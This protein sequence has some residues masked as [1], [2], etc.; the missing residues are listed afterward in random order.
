MK[1]TLLKYLTLVMVLFVVG[2]KGVKA[3]DYNFSVK[4]Y[5]TDDPENFLTSYNNGTAV[6]I[7]AGGTVNVGEK[8]AVGVYVD[9]KKEASNLFDINL[10]WD[11]N[12]LTPLL[13][14]VT[15]KTFGKIDLRSEY[16]GGIQPDDLE[17]GQY[18]EWEA[19]FKK[20]LK[21]YKND[22]PRI[23]VQL[24][25]KIAYTKFKNSGIL[26]WQF[27][28]VKNDAPANSYFTFSY[29]KVDG[30]DGF[31]RT[32]ADITVTPISF[33]VQNNNVPYSLGDI[34]G[35]GRIDYGDI[36][37]L[38]AYTG[39]LTQLSELEKSAADVN[40]D[41]RVNINDVIKLESIYAEI[42]QNQ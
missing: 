19:S 38:I 21:Y 5:K 42:N 8:I 35:N 11:E 37:L 12:I 4:V 16:E 15:G 7:P 25:D 23:N 33:K 24:Q 10:N 32:E 36:S 34:N 13:S 41:G 1:K 2:S 29:N 30:Y 22:L 18:T 9:T 31:G 6:E 14:E 28:Q 17:I 26:Y 3:E 39:K 40:G 20:V 27:F